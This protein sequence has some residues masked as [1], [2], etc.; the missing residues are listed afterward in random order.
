M[1]PK[2]LLKILKFIWKCWLI[3]SKL[4]NENLS[5]INSMR[6]MHTWEHEWRIAQRFQKFPDG[7]AAVGSFP[8]FFFNECT[9]GGGD[10]PLFSANST[11]L[12]NTCLG[13]AAPSSFGGI[14]E[15]ANAQTCLVHFLA[16]IPTYQRKTTH[17]L[18][19]RAASQ[20]CFVF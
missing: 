19:H 4:L 17:P 14:P 10:F 9:T 15:V 1:L 13:G 12:I 18:P 3:A 7:V 11:P 5:Y 20:R 6:M 2:G 16:R 8:F